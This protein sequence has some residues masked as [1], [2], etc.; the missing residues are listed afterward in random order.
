MDGNIFTSPSSVLVRRRD[1]ILELTSSGAFGNDLATVYAAILS[2]HIRWANHPMSRLEKVRQ[3]DQ[4]LL[5]FSAGN[6]SALRSRPRFAPISF[7]AAERKAPMPIHFILARTPKPYSNPFRPN[8]ER[9]T[10]TTIETT[11][12]II[13]TIIYI[14]MWSE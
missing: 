5:N 2:A 9:Q 3:L 8:F 13:L 6:F 12:D 7:D 14:S 1:P 10:N 11:H 4:H